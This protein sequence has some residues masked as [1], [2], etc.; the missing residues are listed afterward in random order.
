MCALMRVRHVNDMA[1]RCE[2]GIWDARTRIDMLLL[3]F[4]AK[5]LTCPQDCTHFR[6]LCLSISD[7][8]AQAIAAPSKRYSAKGNTHR[9]PWA[10]Q[11]LAAADRLHVP[12]DSIL[13]F[14]NSLVEL[15]VQVAGTWRPVRSIAD[16]VLLFVL[17]LLFPLS[18]QS[19][20]VAVALPSDLPP[21][22]NYEDG[23]NCWRLPGNDHWLTALN[24]WSDPVRLATFASLRI[25][26]NYHRQ[27]EVSRLML[28]EAARPR[29]ELRRY[30]R[31][32]SGSFLEPYL[33]LN[34]S[35]ARRIL[36][37][38][39]DAAPN[40]GAVR[41]RPITTRAGT[42]Q[43][44]TQ[45]PRLDE[46][47][48]ACYLC[49]CIDGVDGVYWPESIEHTLLTCT[50]HQDRRAALVRS[51]EQ[52]ADETTTMTVTVDVATPNFNDISCLFAIVNLCT[53]IPN[54]PILQQH[55][56]Q[57][58]PPPDSVRQTMSGVHTRSVT[59]ALEQ[60]KRV[61][62]EA[63]RRGP[64]IELSTAA[65]RLAAAWVS[66]LLN[67]W[68]VKHRDCRSADPNTSPGRRLAE[69]I[70]TYHHHIFKAR[71]AAL[72]RSNAFINRQRDP[73]TA[74]VQPQLQH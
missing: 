70:G 29:T 40:E 47:W 49:P 34:M 43:V 27:Q 16:K 55:Q 18:V 31:I 72:Q 67:D 36:Q 19:T 50:F 9:Q 53:T 2:F 68:A 8:S 25:R 44:Q 7:L 3:R 52:F 59:A 66:C 42:R 58:P 21:V 14:F 51:L 71:R 30:I 73:N 46:Q 23:V 17:S 65:A 6:A 22:V 4:W 12:R 74:D 38:R 28:V 35:L 63:R 61:H 57:P 37:A 26:A 54:Q 69:L 20:R 45:L 41:R 11:A 48:R 39:A 33:F 10:Q 1:L 60:Q 64:Q 5:L 13:K 15:H 62:A 24:R 56:P 32:K